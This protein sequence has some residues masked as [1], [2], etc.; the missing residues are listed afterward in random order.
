MVAATFRAGPF[1][2]G[3]APDIRVLIAAAAAGLAA[4]EPF[5]DLYE[6]APGTLQ[7]ILYFLEEPVPSHG[8]NRF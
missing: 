8:G 6:T 2:D 1:P 3:E 5:G 4:R 7:L